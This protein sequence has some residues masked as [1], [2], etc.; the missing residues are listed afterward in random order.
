MASKIIDPAGPGGTDGGP[1]AG[2]GVPADGADAEGGAGAA[3]AAAASGARTDRGA[4]APSEA[5]VASAAPFGPGAV[6]GSEAAV[7]PGA[8]VAFGTPAGAAPSATDDAT[9]SSAGG[10]TDGTGRPARDPFLDNAKFLLIVLVVIGHTW[11]MGLVEGSRTVKAGYLWISAFHMPAFIL[12]SGYFS[13]GFT[14]RPAQLRKLVAGVL[15]P[16]LVFEVLYTAVETA[17]WGK[18]FRLTLTEPTFVCWFLAALFVWRLT[19]PLWRVIPWPLPVA[20]LVSLAAGTSTLGDDLALPRVLMFLP[21]FVLGLALR[22]AHFARLRT[23]VPL[24]W[25]APLVLAAGGAAAYALAPGTDVHWLWMSYGQAELGA[26][27]LPYLLVRLALFAVTALMTG[28]FLAVV[29]RRT[30]WITAFGAVT[31]YPYLLHG[32]LTTAAH[33]YGW[34]APLR[35]LGPLGAGLLTVCGAAVAVLLSTAPVRRLARPLIEPPVP[36]LT[37][38][39]RR[40]RSPGTSEPRTA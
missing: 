37:R 2:S 39:R 4:R 11:P 13:R 7:D 5:P 26:T 12:L 31:L 1:P 8:A 29:P 10:A 40:G 20:V 28:A 32:L 25:C 34:D 22:P 18:P 30:R 3:P 36:G 17:A 14:G 6:A 19:V 24:R 21:W 15:V 27:T 23:S 33:G 38:P 9:D 16:Y 35:P